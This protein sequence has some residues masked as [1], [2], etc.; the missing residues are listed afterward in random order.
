MLTDLILYIR[1]DLCWRKK[2]K[3]WT[4]TES[5]RY[6]FSLPIA[7]KRFFLLNPYN[8]SVRAASLSTF[9]SSGHL[10]ILRWGDL[11]KISQKWSISPGLPF[12]MDQGLHLS[13][14][15]KGWREKQE[16]NDCLL[17]GRIVYLRTQINIRCNTSTFLVK[18]S[19][20]HI[21]LLCLFLHDPYL[22]GTRLDTLHD[23]WKSKQPC[24]V[25]LLVKKKMHTVFLSPF[26]SSFC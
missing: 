22:P 17:W 7:I 2:G 24:H 13:W 5:M 21:P 15:R 14:L 11:P 25:I 20:K 8:H 4:I 16:N 1:Q 6:M 12:S 3:R 18:I 26:L 19:F 9:Y 23:P 10:G